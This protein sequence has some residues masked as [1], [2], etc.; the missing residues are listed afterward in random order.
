MSSRYLY[1][2]V[3]LEL[4]RETGGELRPRATGKPFTRA[5]YYGEKA[6]YG[7]GAVYGVSEQNAVIMHQ[8]DS[9]EYP[10]AGVSTTPIFENAVGYATHNGKYS[11]GF[12]YKID[13]HLLS[14][15][16][17]TAYPVAE[18]AEKPAIPDDEEIILVASDF[19]R[20][21]NEI[22]IEVIDV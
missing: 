13:T 2:G 9:S 17:V 8:Q 1:R 16:G 12:V 19:G 6:Y 10:T 7:A 3:N 15:F 11:A 18:H 22:V 5:V 20:L 14:Q 21:P 4:H